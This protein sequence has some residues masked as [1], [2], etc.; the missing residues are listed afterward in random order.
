MQAQRQ[1]SIKVRITGQD[2]KRRCCNLVLSKQGQRGAGVAVV[3]G[4]Q[5]VHPEATL[6]LRYQ[7]HD[8]IRVWETVGGDP[9]LA[10]TAKL[11]REHTLRS[12]DLGLVDAAPPQGEAT[13]G[14]CR[15]KS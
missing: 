11:R 13:A 8:G 14:D 1:V 4:K 15:S 12:G 9:Q 7:P 6:V 2:G 5:E 10:V 3:D